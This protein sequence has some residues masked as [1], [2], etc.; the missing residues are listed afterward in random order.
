MT[1]TQARLIAQDVGGR[2]IRGENVKKER[3]VP[4]FTY[5]DFLKQY[6][7]QWVTSHRKS[8]Q[9]TMNSLNS[10]FGFLMD[11]PLEDLSSIELEQWRTNRLREGRKAATINRLMVALKASVNWAV[12]HDLIK[13]NPLARLG[14]LKESESN[15]KV[16]Y[17]SNEERTHLWR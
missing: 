13:E 1:V 16:R 15:V 10:A 14:R 9:E 2:V 3:P 12:N 17:L 4:K 8:G 7:E 6:Y 11:Q 5:G